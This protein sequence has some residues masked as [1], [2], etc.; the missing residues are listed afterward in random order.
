VFKKQSLSIFTKDMYLRPVGS[1]DVSAIVDTL[2]AEYHTAFDDKTTGAL[3][4]LSGGYVQYLQL[5]IIRLH[6]EKSIPK[7]REDLFALLS[8]D[9]QI[10][11]QSEELFESLTKVEKEMLLQIKQGN[12]LSPEQKESAKYLWN[13]GIVSDE[14]GKTAFFSQLFAEYLGTLSMV[15]TTG[16]DFTKKEHLLYTF[17][18]A[19]ED[20]LC[21]REAI[22][23]AVWP[24]SR[25]LGVSDW[26]IDRLV[27]RL[28]GKLKDHHSPYQVM[29]VVTRGYKLVKI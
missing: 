9:E 29:T 8:K 14:G 5:A 13:T 4:E 27:A 26:A 24:E 28:R 15:L 6:E 20:E 1:G 12:A 17:L 16:K 21:E 19:H 23:E 2:K 11:F 10:V 22:I 3:V 7:A 25:D 18:K